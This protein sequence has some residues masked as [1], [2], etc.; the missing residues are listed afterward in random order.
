MNHAFPSEK[1]YTESELDKIQD[2]ANEIKG[3]SNYKKRTQIIQHITE[4]DNH[5]FCIN[6]LE[7]AVLGLMK[8]I[9]L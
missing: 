5:V 8:T 1:Q 9:N 2:D 6:D 3:D 4:N 7:N